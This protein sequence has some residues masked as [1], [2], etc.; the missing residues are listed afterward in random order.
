MRVMFQKPFED[1]KKQLADSWRAFSDRLTES[2]GFNLLRERYRSLKPSRR[3]LLKS[4]V[5]L[6]VITVCL[7]PSVY[8]FVLSSKELREF[9]V[10]RDLSLKLLKAGRQSGFSVFRLN[11]DR[12]KKRLETVVKKYA[13]EDF[14][15]KDKRSL[16]KKGKGVY[17]IDFSFELHPLNVR[18]LT[19]L[20]AELENMPQVRLDSLSIK[21][22]DHFPK[23]YHTS[24][25][26][27]AFVIRAKPGGGFSRRAPRLG[28]SRPAQGKKAVLKKTS[29]K[30]RSASGLSR[31][32]SGAR[33]GEPS[34]SRK[35]PTK[36]ALPLEEL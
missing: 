34:S 24:Y 11:Q 22:S 12:L 1:F 35:K 14:K 33:F 4:F 25:R 28:P 9:E 5:V 13:V 6:L 3:K 20:G 27:S 23:H 29:K 7:A 26:L 21:E 19:Q 16:L 36:R 10:K 31:R 17:K 18:Q 2:H 32:K 30:S 15:I 8:Y